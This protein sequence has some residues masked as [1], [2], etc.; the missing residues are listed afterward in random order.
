MKK[1]THRGTLISS[2]VNNRVVELRETKKF[3]V[4]QYGTK[5][6]K[7]TGTQ[8]PLDIWGTTRLDVST[9]KERK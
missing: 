4:D 1:F 3:W 6:R 7:L 9:V 8:V 5:Y 2:V